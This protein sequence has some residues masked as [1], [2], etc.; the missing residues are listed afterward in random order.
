MDD[1]FPF[2]DF[3]FWIRTIDMFLSNLIHKN[4]NSIKTKRNKNS[5]NE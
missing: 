5:K 4:N 2:L 3:E 1:E